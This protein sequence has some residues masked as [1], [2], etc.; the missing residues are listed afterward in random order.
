MNDVKEIRFK[1]Q[2]ESGARLHV[3]SLG[4]GPCGR[5]VAALSYE[6]SLSTL[7]IRQVSYPEGFAKAQEACLAQLKEGTPPHKGNPAFWVTYEAFKKEVRKELFMYPLDTIV[8]RIA[9]VER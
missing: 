7:T 6:I 9:A 2:H 1:V 8:G 4:M 3:W 5:E